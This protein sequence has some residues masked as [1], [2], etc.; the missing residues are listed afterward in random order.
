MVEKNDPLPSVLGQPAGCGSPHPLLPTPAA[1]SAPP[2]GR[3]V[4]RRPRQ[5]PSSPRSWRRAESACSCEPRR[6]RFAGRGG[7]VGGGGNG[8]QWGSRPRAPAAAGNAALAAPQG[9][10]VGHGPGTRRVARRRRQG[11]RAEAGS[12]PPEP[13][14]GE[15]SGGLF[16]RDLSAQVSYLTPGGFQ[17]QS[18]TRL[19][20]TRRVV[21]SRTWGVGWGRERRGSPEAPRPFVK[22]RACLSDRPLRGPRRATPLANPRRTNHRNKAN[23]TGVLE[24][25]ALLSK[26]SECRSLY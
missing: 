26:F 19:E 23:L 18:G 4:E 13:R 1:T 3:A 22:E 17:G 10:A 7:G 24:F 15:S 12:S 9:V 21:D 2:G 25:T 11:T 5:R 20:V 14:I 6:R 8:F 16:R